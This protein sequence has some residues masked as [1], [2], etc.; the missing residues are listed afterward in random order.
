MKLL[1]LEPSLGIQ[2]S[3]DIALNSSST[4][5]L[6]PMSSFVALSSHFASSLC[7]PERKE[8]NPARS[9]QGA[10]HET[11]GKISLEVS[12]L[13]TLYTCLFQA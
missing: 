8:S 12:M 1:E 11:A 2:R 4:T 6:D 5:G 3:V 13:D 9:F 10:L 7:G